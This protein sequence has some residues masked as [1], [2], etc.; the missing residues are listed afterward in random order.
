MPVR[1]A[2]D[3]DAYAKRPLSDS[4]STLSQEERLAAWL[5]QRGKPDKAARIEQRLS[6]DSRRKSGTAARDAAPR[7]ERDV[8]GTSL[9]RVSE[10]LEAPTAG[11]RDR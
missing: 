4:N 11:G 5:R 10:T 8:A 1:R 3:S 2:S 7:G 9:D 6:N